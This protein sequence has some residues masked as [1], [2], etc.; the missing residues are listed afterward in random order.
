MEN[1]LILRYRLN[2]L[3]KVRWFNH[4]TIYFIVLYYKYFIGS[5]P[6]SFNYFYRVR[7]VKYICKVFFCFIDV[8]VCFINLLIKRQCYYCF[9][10]LNTAADIIHMYETNMNLQIFQ[11]CQVHKSFGMYMF[12]DIKADISEKYSRCIRRCEKNTKNIIQMLLKNL[13][14]WSEKCTLIQ[15]MLIIILFSCNMNSSLVHIPHHFNTFIGLEVFNI[16]WCMV[17]LTFHFFL[18]RQCLSSLFKHWS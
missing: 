6:S 13:R 16:K 7:G 8:W 9:L 5:C 2:H 17:L 3:K 12:N 11:G 4:A 1:T 14:K 10:S 18:N 15:I